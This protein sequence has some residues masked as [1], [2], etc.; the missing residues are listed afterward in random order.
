MGSY[1]LSGSVDL[2]CRSLLTGTGGGSSVSTVN[3]WWDIQGGVPVS[4]GRRV[5]T[6][7]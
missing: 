7:M 5:S 1:D 2:R 4:G 6:E 3:V